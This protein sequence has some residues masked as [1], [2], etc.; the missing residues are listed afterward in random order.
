MLT[1]FRN[2]LFSVS[3]VLLLVGCT[4]FQDKTP[5]DYVA[6]VGDEFLLK[7]ELSDLDPYDSLQDKNREAEIRLWVLN[8]LL[9]KQ[10]EKNL[11]EDELETIEK[12]V[13]KY[14]YDL[15]SQAYLREIT[16]QKLDT[17]IDSA[18]VRQYYD[19]RK[20]QYILNED[21]VKMRYVAVDEKYED[22]KKLKAQF[23]RFDQEEKRYLDSLSLTFN[24]YFLNDSI[25]IRKSDTFDRIEP[26][27]ANNESRYLRPGAY[28]EVRDS[29]EIYLVKIQEILER[30]EQAPLSYVKPIIRQILLNK[31]KLDF[32]AQMKKDLI[33]DAIE[34]ND[35]EIRL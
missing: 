34:T 22:L 19:T 5:D 4:Y 10:A 32:I 30:G 3:A 8:N 7:E 1:R 9:V 6:R 35:A 27:T 23:K 17:V 14:R 21:L 2:I 29:T 12:L 25:W 20:E 28:F 31:R 11:E 33:E 26:L 24:S 15:Y 18:A 16:K 13:N